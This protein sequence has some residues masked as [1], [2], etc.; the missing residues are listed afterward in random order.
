MPV[1]APAP[2]PAPVLPQNPNISPQE[3]K[4]YDE[5]ELKTKELD[6]NKEK[7][8]MLRETDPKDNPEILKSVLEIQAAQ[9]K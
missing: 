2:A 8:K 9:K 3:Q 7:V 6:E 1:T 4:I 5:I